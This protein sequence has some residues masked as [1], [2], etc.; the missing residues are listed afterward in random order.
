MKKKVVRKSPGTAASK[1]PAPLR[2][3]AGSKMEWDVCELFAGVGG[4]RIGLEKSGWKVKF[5]SQWE[6]GT[7]KQ[8]ASDCY[9]RHFG[10]AGHSNEDIATVTAKLPKDQKALPDH[11]LLVGGFPCQDYSVATTQAKGIAGKKGVLWWEIHKILTHKQPRYVLLENVD[12]L[13]LSPTLQRGR[14]FAVI[15]ACMRD[16]GYAVEW[17]VINAAEYGFPQKRRRTFIFG[18]RIDTELGEQ[19][20][21]AWKK[22]QLLDQSGFFARIF[23]VEPT[24]IAGGGIP[25][26]QSLQQVSDTFNMRFG[27]AGLMV[28]SPNGEATIW[29]HKTVPAPVAAGTLGS[30]LVKGAP[31][32]FYVDQKSLRLKGGDRN[33]WEYVKGS[34]SEERTAKTGFKY[35]YTEGGIP[36]PDALDKPSRTILTGDGNRRPNRISHIIQDPWTQRYRV[37]TPVEMERLNGFPDNWTEGMPTTRRYFCMGNALVVGLIERMA[38]HLRKTVESVAKGKRII[39]NVETERA[40]A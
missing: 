12:R 35:H 27:N 2:R 19:M 6:P 32:E 38:K 37:L 8:H 9:V 14:D 26:N 23:P 7:K 28:P 3:K 36:F 16:L 11:D 24:L 22:T 25:F 21:G 15:L 39:E 5:S 13:L 34:K 33:N 4:F 40:V 17:R 30:I 1:R 29:T 18:V 31:E 10:P 20:L